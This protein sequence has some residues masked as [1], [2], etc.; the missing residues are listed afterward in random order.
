MACDLLPVALWPVAC[1]PVSYRPVTIWLHLAGITLDH[2]AVDTV[3]AS[4]FLAG[5]LDHVAVNIVAAFFFFLRGVKEV[6]ANIPSRKL[7]AD[8]PAREGR[9]LEGGVATARRAA[10]RNAFSGLRRNVFV[11]IFVTL[12][13]ASDITFSPNCS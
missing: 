11:I 6:S 4:I 1:G 13:S 8:K 3:A 9:V 12:M 5:V 7:P 2:A 10:R